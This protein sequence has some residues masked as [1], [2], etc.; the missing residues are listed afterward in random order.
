ME[1]DVGSFGRDNWHS[2][3]EEREQDCSLV[4]TRD[5]ARQ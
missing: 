4:K 3:C 1:K 2:K 5:E